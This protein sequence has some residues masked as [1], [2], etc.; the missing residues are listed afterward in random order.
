M[1][2]N[3][4]KK[5]APKNSTLSNVRLTFHSSLTGRSCCYHRQRRDSRPRLHHKPPDTSGQKGEP[6]SQA[7]TPKGLPEEEVFFGTALTAKGQEG[8]VDEG[9]HSAGDAQKHKGRPAGQEGDPEAAKREEGPG[10]KEAAA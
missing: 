7:D 8:G 4:Q 6:H 5:P 3:T 1:K 10:Q 9:H 2:N